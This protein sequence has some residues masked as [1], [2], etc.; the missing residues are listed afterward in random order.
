MGTRLLKK[1][2]VD[3]AKAL[4]RQREINEGLK[5]AKRVD[6][7]RETH[8]QEETSLQTFRQKTLA[9]I[10]EEITKKTEE[11]DNLADEVRK[12]ERRKEEALKPLTEEQESLS[13]Q[14]TSLE[15]ERVSFDREQE[16]LRVLIKTADDAVYKAKLERDKAE[17][18]RKRSA[19]LLLEANEAKEL[20]KEALKEAKEQREIATEVRKSAEE[21]LLQRELAIASVERDLK[22][23][24]ENLAKIEENQRSRE[25]A[26]EDKYATLLRTEQRLKHGKR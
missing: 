8:A 5:I 18:D 22:N 9:E 13:K 10:H 3:Q 17:D 7:L 12:L 1:S 19:A 16:R 6:I 14:R 2:E 15:K 24:A 4:D 20:A 26:L 25:R 23:K 11:R 21:G